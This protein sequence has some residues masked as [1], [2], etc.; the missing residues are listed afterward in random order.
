MILLGMFWLVLEGKFSLEIMLLGA[1]ACSCVYCFNR[2][3]YI[4]K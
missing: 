1:V 2:L 4:S 3:D